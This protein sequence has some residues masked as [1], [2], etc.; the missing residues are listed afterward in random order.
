MLWL[1]LIPA[2]SRLYMAY[3]ARRRRRARAVPLAGDLGPALRRALRG[4]LGRL[5]AAFEGARQL[6]SFQQRAR[7]LPGRA[8]SPFV[9]AGHNLDAARRSC[10]PRSPLI[11]LALRRLPLAYGAYVLAALALPLSYPVAAQPLM[12]L[13]RFLV[14]LFPLHLALGAWLAAHPRARRPLLGVSAL[15]MASSWRSSPPG[16]GS[17]ER[18]PSAS[19]RRP[20]RAAGAAWAQRRPRARPPCRPP[21]RGARRGRPLGLAADRTGRCG[22]LRGAAR[23]ARAG[24]G[25]RA[26][27]RHP[28]ARVRRR[29]DELAH[30]ARD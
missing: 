7:L 13:P 1:A 27:R 12:S 9:A 22:R 20:A 25:R 24:G 3:W 4:R 29:S 30:P 6:L 2:A 14:V 8:G 23:G 10:W 26:A 5:R 11:V 17:P 19:D 21:A 15:L 18:W 16:T 28:G